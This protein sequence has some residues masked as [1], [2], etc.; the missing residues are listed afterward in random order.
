ML[1]ACASQSITPSMIPQ[2]HEP[3]LHVQANA[4][5]QL[6]LPISHVIIVVQENRS[7]DNLFNGFPGADT[8]RTGLDHENKIIQL[9]RRPLAEPYDLDHGTIGFKDDFHDGLMNGFDTEGNASGN[10]FYPYS[11]TQQSDVQPLWDLASQYTLADRMFTSQAGPSFPAHQYLIAGQTGYMGN[12]GQWP[13]GCDGPQS[14]PE[15]FDYPTLG[16][17]MDAAHVTWRYYSPGDISNPKTYGIWLAYDAIRHIRYGSDWTTDISMPETNFFTDL[18]LG[19]LPNVSWVIPTGKNSDHAGDVPDQGPAWVASV[20]NAVGESQY[21]KSSVIFIV[22]DDWG[23]WYDHVPP[24]QLDA[25]GLGI[26]V[27]LIVVSPYARPKYVSHV[28]HEF[29]S[30]L[31]FVEHQFGVASLGTTDVRA[32]DLSD[33]FLP[34]FPGEVVRPFKHIQ[35]KPLVQMPEEAPDD[36]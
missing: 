7:F 19:T 5:R 20:V 21:W 1:T 8:V 13:W 31:K 24:P 9:A 12:P 6:A 28:D 22:W 35:S 30:I 34:A 17:A 3:G 18:S 23:G 4:I 32:D 26:R 10:P 2:R 27:P 25:N 11:Y 33:C 15:C 29:G 14:Q 16:D 36:Y